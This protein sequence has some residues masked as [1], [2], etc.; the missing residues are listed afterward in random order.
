MELDIKHDKKNQRFY[1]I[2]NGKEAKLD[3]S[4]VDEETINFRFTYVPLELRGKGIA[5]KIVEEGLRYAIENNYKIIPS[6]S[7]VDL[8]IERNEKYKNLLL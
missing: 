1:A 2:L 3:Y 8:F 5:A 7:Y 6:C 4:F